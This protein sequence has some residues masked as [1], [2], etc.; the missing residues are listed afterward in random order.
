M[1]L[2]LRKHK[3]VDLSLTQ[4]LNEDF[5]WKWP[6]PNTSNLQFPAVFGRK[7][8]Q[9]LPIMERSLL[10]VA[11]YIHAFTAPSTRVQLNHISFPTILR[12]SLGIN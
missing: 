8:F 6:R 12:I 7:P 4:Q 10:Y 1:R 9:L 3:G 2:G 11:L 5:Y